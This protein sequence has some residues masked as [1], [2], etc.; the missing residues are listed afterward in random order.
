MTLSL[1]AT[2]LAA[3]GPGEWSLDHQLGWFS[4]PGWTG[5]GIALV[6]GLGGG[7]PARHLLAPRR[8]ENVGATGVIRHRW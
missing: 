2:G 3:I 8:E 4:P 7:R 5:L 1:A 6:G